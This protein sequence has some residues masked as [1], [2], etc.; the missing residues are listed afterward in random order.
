MRFS[1]HVFIC[2]NQRP[3]CDPRGSCCARGSEAVRQAFKEELHRRG[4]K[5]QVRANG[6]G[7]LDACAHGPSVVV[8]P[9]GVWYGG[10]RPEDVAEIVERHLLGG[11]PVER[12]RLR[13]LEAGRPAAPGQPPRG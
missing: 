9:E 6:A 2:E 8:Y 3:E 4:L 11:Q 13:E 7:C 12:L 5:G 10:V 1:H